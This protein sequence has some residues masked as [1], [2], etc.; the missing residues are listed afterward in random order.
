MGNAVEIAAIAGPLYLMLGLSLW[1][2]PEP[3]K[4]V[5][6]KLKKDHHSLM[7]SMLL[8]GTLGILI[9]RMYNVWDTTVWV[10]VTLTGWALILKSVGYF[11]LPG[12]TIQSL[13]EMGENKNIMIFDALVT[14][15]VGVVLTYYVYFI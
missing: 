7:P 11:L 2:Y 3:W 12:K 1:F 10:L 4:K 13:M 6:T 15:V 5:M 8:F 9:V 14:V